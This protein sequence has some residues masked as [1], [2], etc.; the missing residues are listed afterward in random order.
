MAHWAT[1]S[2]FYHVYPLGLCG[3]PAR[4]D[5]V[6]PPE[7]RLDRL[8]GWLGHLR[9][10]GANALYLG[11]VFESTTHGYDTA[12]CYHVE[13]RAALAIA[14]SSFPSDCAWASISF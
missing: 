1:D 11:P 6:S 14:R 3:A 5:F 7:L 4:N 2:F 10:L 9:E 8:H 12:D 13:R